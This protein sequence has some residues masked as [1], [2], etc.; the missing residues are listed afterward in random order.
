MKKVV[1]VG[2]GVTNVLLSILLKSHFKNEMD[3]LIIEKNDELLKKLT[4]TGN[5]KCNIL[6][7]EF[8]DG[9]LINNKEIK[10]S[11]DSISFNELY[12]FY[13]KLGLP[14]IEK[15]NLI[16]PFNESSTQTRDFLVSKLND[17]GVKVL[18]GKKVI[19]YSKNGEIYSILLDDFSKISAD[20]ASF[21]TGGKSYKVLGADDSILDIFK[22][23]NYKVS[24]FKPA[25]CAIKVKENV[26][27]LDGVRSKAE[28]SV[29]ESNKLVFKESGEVLFKKDGLSGI[30]IFNA[31][32]F[33]STHYSSLKNIKISLNLISDLDDKKVDEIKK[34]A[35]SA[36]IL[37]VLTNKK[38][39]EY[40]EKL[41]ENVDKQ[42]YLLKNLDF[43]PID[44]YGFDTAQISVGGIELDNLTKDLESKKEPNIY[45]GGELIDI[46]GYCGGYNLSMCLASALIIYK[47]IIKEC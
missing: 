26:K 37:K 46:S 16:Y 44:F 5:G 7:K 33:I 47:K 41:V 6:N 23:H 42:I 30:V 32:L 21:S 27:R 31:S 8:H 20:L 38:I 2:G 13:F 39:A 25:L 12:D 1:L 11:F 36:A 3:V 4:I 29:Y 18:T 40:V 24:E 19:D 10:E 35:G 9:L 43:T 45:F 34:Y 14:L 15:G 28:V 17:L 22:K